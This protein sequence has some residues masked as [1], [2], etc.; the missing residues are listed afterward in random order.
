LKQP[1][2]TDARSRQKAHKLD[3]EHYFGGNFAMTHSSSDPT[4]SNSPAQLIAASQSSP[5]SSQF[6][7][8]L[9]LLLSTVC[10]QTQW[11][12]GETWIPSQTHPILELSSA[13]CVDDTL[14][15]HRAI[16]W[17]QFQVC[18]KEF[19][20]R[21]GEGMPGRVWETNQPEWLDDA[22][23]ES[24]AYFLRNKIAKALNAKACFGV[25][26][27]MERQLVAVAI[28][29]MSNARS[30]DLALMKQTQVTLRKFAIS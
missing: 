15:I 12:Y 23:V 17:V 22:S 4:P 30:P 29:F 7:A 21:H 25:P 3:A 5:P 24:E 26:I 16:S 28:F 19:T 14:E 11:E 20:L 27:A 2:S 9:T 1:Q 6:I 10:R 8:A 13:W 18:S